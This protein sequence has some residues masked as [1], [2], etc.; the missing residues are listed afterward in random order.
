M[1]EQEAVNFKV[2]GSS[3]PGG[4]LFQIFYDSMAESLPSRREGLTVRLQIS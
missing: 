3:P 1:A 4:A 2:G